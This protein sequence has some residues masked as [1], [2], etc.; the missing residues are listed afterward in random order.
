MLRRAVEVNQQYFDWFGA[1]FMSLWTEGSRQEAL[2]VLRTWLRSHPE[3][4]ARAEILRHYEDS[5]R[6]GTE[7][8]LPGTRTP[9]RARG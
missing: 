4:T 9:R 2:E 5:L 1:L 8:A 6:T 3:D 7:R